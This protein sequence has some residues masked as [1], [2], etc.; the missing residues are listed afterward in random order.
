MDTCFI[1]QPQG[2]GDIIFIQKI[3][4][5][6]KQ[7]GYKI[8]F[9]L[10]EYYEWLKP[11]LAQ[12]LVEFPLMSNDR[13]IMEPFWASDRFYYLMGSTW[14]LFRKPVIS[15][16][17]V[18][19]SCGP[20]TLDNDEMMTSKYKVSDADWDGW[21]DYVKLNRNIEKEHQL[22]YEVLGLKDGDEYTLICESCSSHRI[23]IPP[24]GNSVYMKAVTGYTLFDWI[25]VIER[26]SRI[27]TI[28][29][30]VP[31]LA[32]VYLRKDVPCHLI[33]RY[34]PPTFV[35]LPK[36]FK[37]NWQYCVTVEDLVIDV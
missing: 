19:L 14:A 3:V 21:Q 27:I 25:M 24:V 6:Y 35:D 11:Y 29:T 37:L 18:Y 9:P 10:F 26:C 12:D 30:S 34:T 28:D 1:Y 2:V 31:I 20:A 13:K 4:H 23:D 16:D 36:I 7:K 5:D 32:E 22:F 33:N 15:V 17:F 8:I